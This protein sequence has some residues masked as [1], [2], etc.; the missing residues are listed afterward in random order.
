MIAPFRLVL[1]FAVVVLSQVLEASAQTSSS[2]WSTKVTVGWTIVE[3]STLRATSGVEAEPRGGSV[4]GV[5]IGRRLTDG[6]RLQTG[7]FLQSFPLTFSSNANVNDDHSL[8]LSGMQLSLVYDL[9][10]TDWLRIYAGP[11]VVGVTG[12]AVTDNDGGEPL[13]AT[14]GT[15]G[16]GAHF[17]VLFPGCDVRGS[18]CFDFNVRRVR[19]RPPVST[20]GRWSAD[21]WTITF[22]VVYHH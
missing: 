11:S 4:I 14:R 19:L 9:V 6:V 22:G 3:E 1:C 7:V 17:G 10:R 20:G 5:E 21:P 16:V 8:S 18:L 15:A 2:D 13:L 12:D